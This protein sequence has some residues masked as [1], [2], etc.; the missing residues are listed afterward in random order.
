[1]FFERVDSMEIS[2][3]RD[4]VWYGIHLRKKHGNIRMVVD[5]HGNIEW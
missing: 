3:D 4:N 1:M 5:L 2:R